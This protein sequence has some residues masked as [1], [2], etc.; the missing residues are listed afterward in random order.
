METHDGRTL[1]Y[2]SI[3]CNAS[4]ARLKWQ[5]DSTYAKGSARVS[6]VR[7]SDEPHHVNKAVRRLVQHTAE[8]SERQPCDANVSNLFLP[9]VS[10]QA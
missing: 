1:K 3:A 7:K 5:Y 8:H 9:R 4:S 2:G 10:Q 6:C